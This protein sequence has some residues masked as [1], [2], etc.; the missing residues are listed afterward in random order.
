MLRNRRLHVV[1]RQCG[2][3]RP[4]RNAFLPSRPGANVE[5]VAV[6][7][8]GRW[9]EAVGDKHFEGVF[10][11]G[12]AIER[13]DTGRFPVA[14]SIGHKSLLFVPID[15]AAAK[16]VNRQDGRFDSGR[17]FDLLAKENNFRSGTKSPQIER[18]VLVNPARAVFRNQQPDFGRGQPASS[19]RNHGSARKRHR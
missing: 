6:S 13:H 18:S 2:Q 12:Q 7:E 19:E 4:S 17:H 10:P 14:L 15:N 11:G 3:P 16:R 5:R 9:T 8:E 1:D